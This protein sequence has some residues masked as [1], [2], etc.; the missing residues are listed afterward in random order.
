MSCFN[1]DKGTSLSHNGAEKRSCGKWKVI[2]P[3][4]LLP[5]KQPEREMRSKSYFA[6]V[7]GSRSKC[8]AQKLKSACMHAY[9]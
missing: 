3:P 2:H 1:K 9:A 5:P 4:P 8:A 6:V 7:G